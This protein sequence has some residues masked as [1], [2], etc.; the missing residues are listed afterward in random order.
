MVLFGRE[1][2]DKLKGQQDLLALVEFKGGW[3]SATRLPGNISDRDKLL[4]LLAHIDTCPWGV[5]CGWMNKDNLEWQK[6]L[7]NETNDFWYQSSI[8]LPETIPIPLF[9]CAR[10]F[11]RSSDEKR[12]EALLQS[13]P[14]QALDKRDC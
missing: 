12:L 3:I 10:L 13:L 5:V 8:E 7:L 14:N 1:E 11:A 2:E 9:F 4:M 6:K